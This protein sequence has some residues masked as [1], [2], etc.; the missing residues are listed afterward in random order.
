MKFYQ[1]NLSG[2]VPAF[3]L[4]LFFSD[5]RFKKVSAHEKVLFLQRRREGGYSKRDLQR[6]AV[7]N[8]VPVV[9]QSGLG[10]GP[11]WPSPR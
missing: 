2:Q 11:S 9:W 8:S 7:F 10:Q 1:L 5:R 3:V 4:L 6:T